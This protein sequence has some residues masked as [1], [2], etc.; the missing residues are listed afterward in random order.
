MTSPTSDEITQS[1]EELSSYRE[2]LSNELTNIA[3]KLRMPK[4]R[5]EHV[6]SES[7][8]LKDVEQAISQLQKELLKQNAN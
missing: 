3:Q 5:V 7:Q 4:E 8:E 6:L 2:R 1:I